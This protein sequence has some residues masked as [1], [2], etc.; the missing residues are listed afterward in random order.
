MTI[1]EILREKV[2][3]A[4]ESLEVEVPDPA[5]VQVTKAADLRFGDFQS[6]IAMMLAKGPWKESA[7]VCRR[8]IGPDRGR[9]SLRDFDR[10]SGL[11]EFHL[12]SRGV[13]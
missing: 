5:R 8:L 9:G 6:N 2:L 3:T 12:E 1:P 7:R 4:L 13:G 10:R 11:F